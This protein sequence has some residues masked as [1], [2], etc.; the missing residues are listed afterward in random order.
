MTYI[1]FNRNQGVVAVRTAEES[2]NGKVLFPF[3]IWPVYLVPSTYAFN[4]YVTP[5]V[6][7]GEKHVQVKEILTFS[8]GS[9]QV[10]R[11]VKNMLQV[12]EILPFSQGNTWA[13]AG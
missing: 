7:T 12:K 13:E 3:Y 1:F 6:K 9:S 5:Y 2:V 4:Q 10:N 11:Q 8:Q